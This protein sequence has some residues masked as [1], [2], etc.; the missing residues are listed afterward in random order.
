MHGL[1]DD[2]CVILEHDPKLTPGQINDGGLLSIKLLNCTE[3]SNNSPL[4]VQ[5]VSNLIMQTRNI[6]TPT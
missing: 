3:R 6:Q 5:D 1:L 2:L 4:F